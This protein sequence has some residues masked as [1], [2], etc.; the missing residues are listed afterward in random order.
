MDFKRKLIGKETKPSFNQIL[1]MFSRMLHRLSFAADFKTTLQSAALG[2]A[3]NLWLV[4]GK[5]G[6][7]VESM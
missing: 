4:A 7:M 3:Q 1:N 2:P 5:L 6:R